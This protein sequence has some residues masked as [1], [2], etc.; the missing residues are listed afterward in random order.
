[1][2]SLSRLSVWLEY[3]FFAGI[4]M[5]QVLAFTVGFIVSL[6]GSSDE[7]QMAPALTMWAVWLL[8]VGLFVGRGISASERRKPDPDP[9]S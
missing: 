9:T 5:G 6:I 8:L 2:P 1:M 3:L 4:I 7:F